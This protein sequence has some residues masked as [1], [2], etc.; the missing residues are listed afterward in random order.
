MPI[1]KEKMCPRCSQTFSDA[2]SLQQ[3][4]S[5]VHGSPGWHWCQLCA[6]GFS[7]STQ[8]QRHVDIRHCGK[9]ESSHA[10]VCPLCSRSP[11]NPPVSFTVQS[12]LTKHLRN[13]HGIPR[14]AAANLARAA[15]PS[16]QTTDSEKTQD[17]ISCSS[18]EVEPVKR[19]FVSG[20]TTCYQCSR[21]DFSAE[22]RAQF[23]AH[24]AKHSPSLAG[25]VQCKE[26]AA[27][28][29]VAATL[30]RHLRITHQ[31]HCDIDTYLQENGYAT[32]CSTPDISTVDDLTADDERTSP[33]APSS[34]SSLTSSGGYGSELKPVVKKLATPVKGD[35]DDDDDAPGECT[36]C[37]RV[38]TTKH[39]LRKHMRVHGMAFIQRT[40]RRL[41]VSSPMS[42]E[43]Q[44]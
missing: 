17:G 19:L 36:V 15:A 41:P 23:V 11:D 24:A 22:D 9:T 12:V 10:Y 18:C 33:V 6:D 40:R 31:M 4:V 25:A 35:Y 14:I 26:C 20:E 3:H 2:E 13:M 16:A 37:Y 7:T 28:F 5:M 38:F 39:L 32:A 21:C 27:S 42:G 29:T 8:L 1:P 30:Y 43:A 34:C 44:N